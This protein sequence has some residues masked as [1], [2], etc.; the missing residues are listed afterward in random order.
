[1]SHGFEKKQSELT[2]EESKSHVT[3]GAQR[4]GSGKSQ[5]WGSFRVRAGLGKPGE[6]CLQPASVDGGPCA[7]NHI[8]AGMWNM[9]ICSFWAPCSEFPLV[10]LINYFSMTKLSILHFKYSQENGGGGKKYKPIWQQCAN[11][12]TGQN[13]CKL[14]LPCLWQADLRLS[15]CSHFFFNL[16]I[17]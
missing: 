2:N 4:M 5:R 14:L 17:A 11:L 8:F 13:V 6:G 16:P 10:F 7:Q 3:D 1:M 12:I 9:P 15:A